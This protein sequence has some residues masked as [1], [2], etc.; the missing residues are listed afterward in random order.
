MRE[1]ALNSASKFLHSLLLFATQYSLILSETL[2]GHTPNHRNKWIPRKVRCHC[3]RFVRLLRHRICHYCRSRGR[4]ING[5]FN[6]ITNGSRIRKGRCAAT[7]CIASNIATAGLWEKQCGYLRD[8]TQNFTFPSDTFLL[9]LAFCRSRFIFAICDS[10]LL[11][12]RPPWELIE[13]IA[14]L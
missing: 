11:P 3:Q 4:I 1:D 5:R 10:Y 9:C 7:S 14:G 2:G 6:R 12:P 13:H 8:F